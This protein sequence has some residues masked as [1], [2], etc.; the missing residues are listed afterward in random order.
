MLQAGQIF[1]G[2]R[3]KVNMTTLDSRK[4]VPF[5]FILLD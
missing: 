4:Y 1:I 2:K 3:G 5:I